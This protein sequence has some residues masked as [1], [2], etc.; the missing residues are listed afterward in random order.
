MLQS[1]T[2]YYLYLWVIVMTSALDSEF[3]YSPTQ[4]ILG[5]PVDPK[6]TTP[7]IAL[8]LL[9]QPVGPEDEIFRGLW[10][11]ADVRVCA[12]GAANRL[13][14]TFHN[15]RNSLVATD[16]EKNY[17]PTVICGDM[18]SAKK[19]VVDYF[20]GL[21]TKIVHDPDQETTDFMKCLK[22]IDG[23]YEENHVMSYAIVAYGGLG[24]RFD[25]TMASISTLYKYAKARPIYLANPGALTFLLTA[26]THHIECR[27]YDQEP[28]CGIL[29]FAESAIVTTKGLRWDLDHNKT[30]FTGLLST[31]NIVD[32]DSITVTTDKGVVWTMTLPNTEN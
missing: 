21:G 13:Y 14:E 25:H 26:G 10:E 12:D 5:E 23:Y 4:V 32:N 2:F 20:N 17:I 18:D 6:G 8:L 16:A 7:K 28:K 29:P 9:N 15:T 1:Y 11:R 3:H 31:S 30:S 22:W 19:D 27:W 24:G